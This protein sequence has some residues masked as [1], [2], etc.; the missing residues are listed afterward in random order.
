MNEAV[1]LVVIGAG[2]VGAAV[3]RELSSRRSVLV[4]ESGPRAAEGVTSRNSGVV[5]CGLYYQ[6]TYD[7]CGIRPKLRAPDETAERD[8]VISLD[9]PGFVNLVGLESP[10]LTAALAIGERVAGLLG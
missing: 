9:R 6:L 7:S 10:G 1:D 8:F 4:L 5:H 2:V 3:A